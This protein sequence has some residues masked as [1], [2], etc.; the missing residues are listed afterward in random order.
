M[1]L[2][3]I[4]Q[5]TKIWVNDPNPNEWNCA[6]K[7]KDSFDNEMNTEQIYNKN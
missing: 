3:Y 7:D 5:C 1:N 2:R 4:V 6:F